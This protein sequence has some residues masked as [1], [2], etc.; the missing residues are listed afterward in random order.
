MQRNTKCYILSGIKIMITQR[1][2]SLVSVERSNRYA[3][4]KL[5]V[6]E[7]IIFSF[8]ESLRYFAV[9]GGY[10]SCPINTDIGTY[11]CGR[12][13]LRAFNHLLFLKIFLLYS[14]A[15]D[16]SVIKNKIIIIVIILIIS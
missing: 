3:T 4:N 10:G 14:N 11:T 9:R 6:V 12:R 16:S 15:H 5:T 13:H 8:Y 7:I 2:V 1:S